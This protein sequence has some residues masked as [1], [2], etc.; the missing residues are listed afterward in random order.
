GPGCLTHA[1]QVVLCGVGQAGAGGVAALDQVAVDL[2]AGAGELFR[3][4]GG[5]VVADRLAVRGG[6][7]DEPLQVDVRVDVPRVRRQVGVLVDVVAQRCGDGTGR[8]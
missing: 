3:Q 6:E 7:Q 4:G 1:V 8:V 5:D 2:L